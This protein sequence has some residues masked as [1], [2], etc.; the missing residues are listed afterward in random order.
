[1]VVT[2]LTY[3]QVYTADAPVDRET[4][5][6]VLEAC[7]AA[8]KRA[9]IF[10]DVGARMAQA[11]QD[12]KAA[13]A[14]E[15]LTGSQDFARQVTADLQAISSDKHLRLDYSPEVTPPTSTAPATEALARRERFEREA[16]YG[17]ERVE[18]L[19]GNVGYLEMRMFATNSPRADEVASAAM[20]F[21]AQADALIIDLRRNTGGNPGMIAYVSSYL[22]DERVHLN[23]L[24]WRAANRTDEFWTRA[25]VAGRKFGGTKAIFVLTSHQTFSGAEEFAYNLQALK[26]ATI[27]GETTGG[28][29]HPVGP[30][31]VGEHFVLALP[32]GRAINPI[33]KTNW[34]GKGVVPDVVV[35]GG[36]ALD[37]ARDLALSA[38]H[39][40]G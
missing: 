20:T 8:L 34:E 23:D 29:A 5:G 1:M 36:E 40:P 10:E 26:R 18:R 38:L 28:G 16:N 32:R 25:D 30:E 15:N 19:N 31:F 11:L 27:V 7:A 37:K 35:P 21:L 12:R 33:T 24:F 39:R 9:Y 3:G 14:Y 17:F 2:T 4:R 22:F 6:K 13:G